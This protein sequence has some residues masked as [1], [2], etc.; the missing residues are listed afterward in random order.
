M[1]RMRTLRAQRDVALAQEQLVTALSTAYGTLALLIAA[2][3]LFGLFAFLVTERKRE[4]GVRLA[5]GARHG[6]VIG[7]FMREAAIL[8]GL[9]VVIGVPA[10][11][12]AT[13]VSA[14][15]MSGGD[16]GASIAVAVA[17]LT[18][19]SMLAVWLPARRAASLDPMHALRQN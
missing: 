17:L 11:S 4:I 14:A 13:R 16:A 5:L 6:Q 15:V 10:A 1:P 18:A 9:G 3:G 2:V 12:A 7:L 8:V 19:V